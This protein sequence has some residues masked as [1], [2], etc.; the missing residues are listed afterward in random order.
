VVTA[1]GLI[2]NSRVNALAEAA[3]PS[4]TRGRYLAAFQYAFALA[5][6][7]APGVVALF[8][9]AIWLPWMVVFVCT[10]LAAAGMAA[11]GPRLPRHAVVAQV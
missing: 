5:G 10:V 2:F 11:I 9:I 8:S 7:A 4:A 3:A 6:V 1:A